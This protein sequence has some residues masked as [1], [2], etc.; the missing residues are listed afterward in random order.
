MS[1]QAQIDA[2]EHLLI[3]VLKRNKMTLYVEGVFDEAKSS[4]MGSD[5]PSGV[6]EKTKAFEYLEQLELQIK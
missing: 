6:G 1:Q 5:G 2:L 4:I 3:V